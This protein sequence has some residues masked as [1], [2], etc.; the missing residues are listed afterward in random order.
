MAIYT[1]TGDAGSTSLFTGQRVSKTH[2]RV[3]AYGTLD[4]LNA[5]LSLCVCAVAEEEQRTLLEALQQHIFWFSA[6]LASDSEQPSPGK[7]YISS[8]EIALL[9]Q[10][11][12]REMARVP[13]LHQ[14]V[15]PGRCEAASCLHLARTVARRAE[16]RLVELAAE[17]TIRQILLRYLNR[18]SD[19]LYALARSE[20]HAAHQRRLV[21][22]IAARYLAASGS[23]A[24]DAPKAQAG[25]LSFHE[26]HQL[27]RQAIEHARQLQVPVVVSIVDAHGT[28]TVTWRMPDALLVSSELAPKKAWT[29]VAMKTATHELA[30][31]VQ[32]GAALYGLESH[33]QGKVVTFGGGYPLWRDGQLIAGLGISGGPGIVAMGMKSGKKV[34]GAGAGNPP[35][36]VDETA[37]LVKAAE[38]IISG[39]AFDYNLPC[40]AEKSLI[41]VA[42]V[43]DRLIQQMQDFD[44]LLLSRQEA[45]TLRAV[46]LPDGAAN[47]KLVGKSPAALLAAAGLAV[48]PRPPRLLIAEVEAND[49]WVTCEQLMPV[50][51]IVR[52]A[53]FDSALALA[54]RVE[55][56]LHHTAIMHSQNVSRLNLAARTLQTSIFVKNGPSYAGIGVGGE[57]FTT[58]TIATP[59]GEGTTSA[60]TFARLRRCVLTNGFS[61]R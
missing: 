24:P 10:T 58:F 35:C 39:A 19:C 30:T 59:T 32:P 18:L 1:R 12:D 21:T 22:E 7:R 26:L 25:S 14:F 11:I 8:E 60:R 28:E 49:P 9:E 43:A 16:R 2:P 38:D 36:I 47:K 15:L 54:L 31:T 33:L 40:I 4:E 6:E 51:P 56:G 41:V 3:E 23:P 52:V 57:G 34:I 37:D 17:V 5:M 45:D 53:D 44:A 48:P 29:A 46:C 13:A 61:I 55:E 50:L 20:D 42:S 27:I